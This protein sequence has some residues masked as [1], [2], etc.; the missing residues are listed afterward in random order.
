M[1]SKKFYLRLALVSFP[2][3]V[4]PALSAAERISFN[5]L[6][7]KTGNRVK[8][9]LVDPETGEDVERTDTVKGY[10]YDRGRYVEVTADDLASIKVE[11]TKVIDIEK[12]VSAAELPPE[13]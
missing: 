9:K 1:A 12:F 4:E 6:N 13:H 7:P 11:S 3:R 8:Q 2:V 5:M 10:E